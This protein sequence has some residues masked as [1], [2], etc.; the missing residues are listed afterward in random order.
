MITI[1]NAQSKWE[2]LAGP[3][4]AAHYVEM[5]RWVRRLLVGLG[6]AMVAGTAAIKLS[7]MY[8][9]SYVYVAFLV[10]GGICSVARLREWSRFRQEARTF[11]NVTAV[12]RPSFQSRTPDLMRKWIEQHR[13]TP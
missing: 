4:A 1:G 7:G 10:W 8:A 2:P 12:E 13:P 5:L 3:A 11:L 9:A 6:I